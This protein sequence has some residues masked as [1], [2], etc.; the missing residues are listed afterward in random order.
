M[1]LITILSFPLKLWKKYKKNKLVKSFARC[2]SQFIISEGSIINSANMIEIGDNVSIGPN[3]VL[4][5]IYKKIIFGNNVL[6]G[7]GITMVSGDHSIRKVGV[8]IIDNHEKLP[9]DDADIIIEDEVWIGAN[10]TVLKGVVIGRGSVVAAGAVLTRSFPPYSI[11]GG[12]PAKII[13]LRFTKE[14]IKDHER[15]LYSEDN[16]TPDNM[17]EWIDVFNKT[18]KCQNQD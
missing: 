3:V 7:P 8:P 12:I 17:L 13:G 1:N 10:V 4:Y 9:E 6:L 15:F 2:G 14:Q 16:Q 11:I 5:S 18:K